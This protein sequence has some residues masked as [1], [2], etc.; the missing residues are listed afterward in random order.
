MAASN[1]M[2]LTEANFRD[3]VLEC[4]QPVLVDFWAE[5]CGPCK[6]MAPVFEKAARDFEPRLR[7]AKID[8]DAEGA[9]SARFNIRSIPTLVMLKRGREIA[10]L[11]GALPPSELNRWIEAHLPAS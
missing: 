4:L 8:S 6:M 2:T 10:R 11:S 5:W 9:L 7:F 1:V 3:Q